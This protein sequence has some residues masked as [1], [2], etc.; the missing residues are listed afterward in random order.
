MQITVVSTSE[1]QALAD[2]VEALEKSMS[3]KNGIL[4]ANLL[5]TEE[6]SLYTGKKKSTLKQYT[7]TGK[8]KPKKVGRASFFDKMELNRVFGITE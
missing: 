8:L 1:F 3:V 6:A 4:N 5:S 7:C 2:R